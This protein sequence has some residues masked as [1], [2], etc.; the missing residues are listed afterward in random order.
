MFCVFEQR[1]QLR[2][3]KKA[4]NTLFLH[5]CRKTQGKEHVVRHYKIYVEKVPEFGGEVLMATGWFTIHDNLDFL[6][7]FYPEETKQIWKEK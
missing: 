5:F 1:E 2:R 6:K 7:S 4:L 3:K